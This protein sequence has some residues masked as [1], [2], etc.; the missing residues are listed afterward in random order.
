MGDCRYNSTIL[1]LS[2]SR[3]RVVSFMPRPLYPRGRSTRYHLDTTLG[4][5]ENR[6]G[7]HGE[8]KNLA[9]MGTRTPTPRPSSQC[10]S[11][12]TESANRYRVW[13]GSGL[14]QVISLITHAFRRI[15]R[16]PLR[17]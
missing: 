17:S 16:C 6:S 3:T 11:R 10:P 13:C 5:P 4:E 7:R 15:R 9:P 8:E 14:E 12:Y 2:I 1:D